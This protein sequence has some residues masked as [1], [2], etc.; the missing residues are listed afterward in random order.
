MYFNDDEIRRI[1]DAA[2]GHLLD[3]AQDFHEL[4]RSGV[5]YNCDCPRCKAAKKL[6]IS[7]AKQVF[8]CFGCK[9]L[10]GGDSVSF[11]M[12]A[13]G[14]TF[15]DALDYLAKKFNVILDQRPVIKKQPAKKMK[16]GSK[17]AK[18]ID[19]DSYCARML[20]ESGLTFEDVTAK[21]YK[22]GDT[23]SIFEQ[24]TFRPGT[25]DE[26]GMLTTKG[27]DVIIEYYDL[28]GMPVV[29]TR[30][31]NK[32]R[33]VGTPQEYYRIRWQFPDAHLDKEGKPYKYKSPRGS[34]T[35][36]YIPERI[37]SLYKSK[38]K[39]PR[40]YIQEGEKKAEKAC[41]HGIPSIAVSG[42]QNLGLYGALPEDLVKI[43]STC[44]VQE[45]AF[46]FDSD[47]DDISSNIRINDQV[48]KRPRCFFYA[49]KNFKEYMRSLK[50]R[51]IFV[52]IFV[53]HINK[54]E[55]GDKGL[56]D[57]L[58]N[59]L[60]GKEEEL[61]ADIEFA[62]NEKKGLGKY[63]EMFKVTTWTDHKLQEL[64]GLHSHEVFAERHADLLRN[65]PEFLFG[66]YRWK[67]DEHGKVILAQPFDDDEK[68]WREVT[69]YDRSQNERIEYEFCYVN[70]QNFLQN[71]GFGRLRRI[72][73]SYQFIHLEPPVVRAIDASDARD[74][75]FQFAKHNC[76]T[77][78]NEMLIKGV[79]QYV[80]PDKLSLLEFIQPNFVK[81]NRESQYFYFDKNCWLV[82]KDSVSELG[83]ENI[84]H[85]IWEEQRKMTPAK[86]LGK[87][88]VTFSR[89]DNTFTYELS[90]AGKKSHYLQFLIN[91]SN[92]TWR[93]S[94]EEI[95]PE[96][97]NENRIH[98]L[99]K[100]CAIGYMVMEAKDNNVARA[101]IGMDGKQSEVGESNGRSGKSLVGELMRNIIPT[102]YIPG[103]RSDLFNDQFVW[104]DIQENTKLVFIDDVLQN[105]NF[106][107]LFPNITG[108][109]SVNY[110]GGRRIT[111]PFA[112]SPKMYIA[113]N[114]AIRGSGSSYTDRQW[115]LAFS[116]FYNDTHKPVDDFGVL[117]FSEWDFEQWNLTWNL[118]ANCVQLYLT[119]GVV[120]APGE[121]L[122]QRKLR[123][124][125]GE[126]LIS[127]ADEYFS[128]EEHLNVRLPRKDLY[129]AFCQ[130]DNQQR[131]FV[132]PTA[133]K[134]KFIMYC[135]WKGYVF[136]PHKYD[137]ITGKPFQVD[138]D[139]KAVVDD[140]SGG[141]EYFTVGTG[142]QPIP[143]EDNSRLPQPTGKLVF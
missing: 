97:E 71:R 132:S 136:N 30:K 137:S 128:G 121:R 139:G 82:T 22:T 26:R 9:E 19:V 86:Y 112:R 18:G 29:F 104:N 108:D 96:E 12:S 50:N 90:E 109:W 33:D 81:P 16:K 107:F 119:Y 88:L 64:W 2:T 55:A 14:M 103:K 66:R 111:L 17:A 95:E 118:L 74:Y 142:A 101:V 138:K 46:I 122:E 45:V 79:S 47:W 63:I 60:R 73:K 123:Q 13:E 75:L 70:S 94:A 54:N 31:D 59:S 56:D 58:A 124:E 32:R 84:T 100:L 7:P 53:G 39:I 3:V 77:E 133:F 78:V 102:A 52:E 143:E 113:T 36:I 131:K 42:I 110:K 57:L 114:H 98:L 61:A 62:C 43:I 69:K 20:A 49:A 105:F 87:P 51:N 10:K 6:S 115:L 34:G 116:D 134:K 25:I 1:K 135:A 67:F 125:M 106:E 65:L 91:T 27:D 76:K 89:Q 93:K 120:Q 40:L 4:K 44:E 11:L 126:T 72:D 48:E 21:V 99:S 92:F 24:R 129:D 5:S 80:G 140:K 68:F 35:P 130:Y 23:Q 15:N 127:W 141:V 38:T 37:R 28:E 85:H 41:K 8:K 117:F 83:Y